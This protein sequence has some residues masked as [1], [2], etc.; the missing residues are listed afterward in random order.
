MYFDLIVF[1]VLAAIVIFVFKRFSS[2]IY[3]IAII[4]IF[5]RIATFVKTDVVNGEVFKIIDKY[6]PENIPTIINTYSTGILST[7]LIWLY[8]IAFVIFE[9][10]II[11]TF[12]KRK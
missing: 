1:L 11:R 2:F 10:Y 5:L 8:V 12:F 9:Y 7:I 3:Y 6:L 4:D